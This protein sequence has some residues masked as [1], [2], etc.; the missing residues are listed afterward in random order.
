[1]NTDNNLDHEFLEL[2]AGAPSER[3]FLGG[4]RLGA[5]VGLFLWTGLLVLVGAAGLFAFAE[6]QLFT[7]LDDA[8]ASGRVTALSAQLELGIAKA[9]GSEKTFF[10]NKDPAIAD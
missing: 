4:M 8:Q 7:T 2:Q 10:Q 6:N 9:R 5:R 1:M 3:T